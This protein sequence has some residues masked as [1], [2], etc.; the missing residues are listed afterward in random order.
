MRT[1]SVALAVCF[2]FSEVAEN[3]SGQVQYTLTDLGMLPGGTWSE[4]GVINNSGQ[5][6]GTA[7]D[8]SGNYKA[9]LY[10]NG[11]M[12]DLGTLGGNQSKANCINNSG[13]VAGWAET[14]SSGVGHAYV[15]SNGTMQDLG[16]LGGSQ[17]EA[18]GIN[19]NEQV[20]GEAY[21]ASGDY[22]AFLYS[23][24]TMQDLGTF[25]GPDSLAFRVN[26][27]GQVVG[28]ANV[29]GGNGTSV[30]GF[31]AFLYSGGSMEDLGT[32]GGPNSYSI[33]I[34]NNGQIAGWA[35]TSDSV[36]HAFLHSGSGSLVATDNLGTFGAASSECLGINDKGQVVGTFASTDAFLYSNGVMHDLNSLIP[37]NSGWTLQVAYGINDSGQI[38]GWGINPSGQTDAFLL[39]PQSILSFQWNTTTG[40]WGTSTNWNPSS[41]PGVGATVTFG[42]SVSSGTAAVALNGAAPVLSNLVF[43]NSNASYWI[44]QGTGT[45][46]LT[47]TGTGSNP[48]A[49]TVV[50]GTHWV[51]APILLGSNLV[52]SSSGRLTLSG[53]ISDGGLGKSMTFEGGGELILSGSNS[54]GGGTT[55]NEGVLVVTNN[56]SLPGGGSLTIG[57]GGVLIFDPSTPVVPPPVLQVVNSVPE[58]SS[59]V[60]FGVVAFGLLGFAWRRKR[61]RRQW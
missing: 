47:L 16:T 46:G 53:N 11:T 29:V 57:T 32:F 60:L 28:W 49:I 8:S 14:S 59:V 43:S 58:P 1:T 9:F 7:R 54:Y 61:L 2:L 12:Q 42:P 44:L 36:P 34:N 31:Q 45:T 17:S 18:I 48:A 5:I 52:V 24:G 37:S 4:A 55:V 26:D 27:K 50:S 13:Q 21:T 6:V 40:I 33:A 38:T 51:Q 39:T 3:A 30:N 10:S 35:D 20:V 23:G 25:G 56:D 19:S 15:Y 41:V 22:H